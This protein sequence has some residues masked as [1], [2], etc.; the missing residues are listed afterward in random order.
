MTQQ[1]PPGDTI[2]P[3]ST[4]SHA[5]FFHGIERYYDAHYIVDDA[6]GDDPNDGSGSET[7]V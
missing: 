5:P 4:N 7:A 6:S 1:P 3:T 2:R